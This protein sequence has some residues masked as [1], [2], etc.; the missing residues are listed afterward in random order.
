LYGSGTF[1]KNI[2]TIFVEIFLSQRSARV[3]QK[4]PKYY[5]A[6]FSYLKKI[7]IPAFRSN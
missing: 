3:L 2:S 7:E 6:D 4:V 5:R 1:L